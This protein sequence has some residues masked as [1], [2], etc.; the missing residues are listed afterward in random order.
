MVVKNI[1]PYP[2]FD[3]W[4]DIGVEVAAGWVGSPV[5][6]GEAGPEVGR[7]AVPRLE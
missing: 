7:F 4:G 3:G 1:A 2:K 5:L 6:V